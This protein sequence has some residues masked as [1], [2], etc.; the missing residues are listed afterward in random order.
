M[1]LLELLRELGANLKCFHHT[2]EEVVGVLEYEAGQRAGA[3]GSGDTRDYSTSK[4]FRQTE[5]EDFIIGLGPRVRPA[6][7]N[8]RKRYL[9]GLGHL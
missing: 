2:R 5:M 9:G 3:N 8:L 4:H 6:R 1:E 7:Y